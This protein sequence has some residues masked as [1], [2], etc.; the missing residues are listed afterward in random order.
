MTFDEKAAEA[1]GKAEAG[2]D[3]PGGPIGIAFD[4]DT[5]SGSSNIRII[6]RFIR[7]L[8]PPPNEMNNKYNYAKK[9]KILVPIAWIHHLIE[10]LFNKNYNTKNKVGMLLSTISVSTNRSKLL[11]KLE[12]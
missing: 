12:L 4:K 1:L 11:K 3:V 8:F 9:Y 10:G 2:Y 5:E 7:L 6:G